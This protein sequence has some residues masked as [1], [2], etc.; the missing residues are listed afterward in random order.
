MTDIYYHVCCLAA[1]RDYDGSSRA[2][3]YTLIVYTV[4]DR[5]C[6]VWTGESKFMSTLNY[7]VVVY[8]IKPPNV[9]VAYWL[10]P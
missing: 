10:N 9:D 5:S 2:A 7:R 8:N 6:T 4:I 3:K 1:G